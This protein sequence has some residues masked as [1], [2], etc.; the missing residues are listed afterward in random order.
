M[1]DFARIKVKLKRRD[2]F[3]PDHVKAAK[4]G[5]L[6]FG[7]QEFTTSGYGTLQTFN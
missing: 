3:L 7:F 4:A 6:N 1:N 5:Q 2:D